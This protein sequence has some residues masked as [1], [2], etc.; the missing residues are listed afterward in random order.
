MIYQ[1]LATKDRSGADLLLTVFRDRYGRVTTIQ[2]ARFLPYEDAPILY[3][4][5]A[6][7]SFNRAIG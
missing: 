6:L 2:Q 5:V 3:E 4:T 1:Y 7:F